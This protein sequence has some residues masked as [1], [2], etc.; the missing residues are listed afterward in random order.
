MKSYLII[1]SIFIFLLNPTKAFT[2]AQAPDYLIYNGDTLVIFSNPLETYF[3]QHPN[4]KN[5]FSELPLLSTGCW[6]G[7]IAYWELRN[8][9]L[10]LK[11]IYRDEIKF[12]I[13]QAITDRDTNNG[14]FA[15]W[16]SQDIPHPY[17]NLVYYIHDAYQSIYE[18][19][20]VFH[21]A[22]GI[23][24][25]TIIYD[26]SKSR[27]SKYVLD[28]NL[29]SKYIEDNI[30]YSKLPKIEKPIRVIVNIT[31][32]DNNGKINEAYIP[33]KRND[34]FDK[35]A[36]RI[37]KSIPKWDVIYKR[38]ERYQQAWSIP[39]IFKPQEK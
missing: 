21:F 31:G 22:A 35:E 34:I 24:K 6:R 4:I 33:R 14:V 2:T 16:V 17:G 7:Y 12:D 38:G 39:V 11:D 26:N 9:S 36:I 25:S 23:L 10:F 37:I 27:R 15:D 30:D 20:K 28:L 8:D 29:L 3:Q 5:P 19:D 18:F 1:I 13:A 32:S